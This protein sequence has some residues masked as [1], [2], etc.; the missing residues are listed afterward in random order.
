[1]AAR[2]IDHRWLA[3]PL[4]HEAE[5]MDQLSLPASDNFSWDGH[6]E[7]S[8]RIL[9]QN[10]MI[11]VVAASRHGKLITLGYAQEM[12]A[13]CFSTLLSGGSCEIIDTDFVSH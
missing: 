5:G 13:H 2:G 3:A 11:G 7:T 8:T 6:P 12:V 4:Q 10:P 9:V 1:M